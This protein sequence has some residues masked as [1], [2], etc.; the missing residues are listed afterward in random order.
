LTHSRF[1]ITVASDQLEVASIAADRIAVAIEAAI[2]ERGDAF[3]S[4]AGGTTPESCYRLLASK[5]LD[6]SKVTLVP[7]DERCVPAGDP[8]SNMTMIGR[9]LIAA[10]AHGL[11]GPVTVVPPEGMEPHAAAKAWAADLIESFGR[12]GSTGMAVFDIAVLGIGPDGHTASLFPNSPSLDAT[13]PTVAVTDAPKPPPSRVSL[14]LP[15]LAAAR[16]RLLL[17]TGR[18]KAAAVERILA[19]ADPSVPASLLPEQATTLLI[20]RAAAGQ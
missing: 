6:W 13:E 18:S 2:R 8:E 10:I 7:G 3:V 17:A 19:G 14:S 16:Q 5:P 9:A 20:D 1:E 4:L 15:T 12:P 11:P